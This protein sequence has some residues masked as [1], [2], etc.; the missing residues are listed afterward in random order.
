MKK[1]SRRGFFKLSG[2]ASAGVIAPA[3]LAM[4]GKSEATTT[5][6]APVPTLDTK[7]AL[8]YEKKEVTKLN[9][10]TNNQP[11]NFNYPDNRSPC[12]VVK[13]G[14]SVPGGVGPDQ[15]IVAYSTMC[16]HMGCPM[17]YDTN[18]KVFKC[19]CHYSMFDVEKDGQ[20]IIGQATEKLPRILLDYDEKTGSISAHA[21]QGLLYGRQANFVEL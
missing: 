14:S 19:G 9:A 12:M 11:V 21:I 4:S 5:A 20:V 6:T 3:A 10:L 7:T 8:P 18:E 15:D 1:L 16:T 17:P 2:A 13:L